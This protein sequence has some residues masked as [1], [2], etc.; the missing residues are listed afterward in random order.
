MMETIR[1]RRAGYPIR[2]LFHVREPRAAIHVMIIIS[3]L[4]SILLSVISTWFLS[5]LI[6]ILIS[7]LPAKLSVRESLETPQTTRLGLLRYFSR[8]KLYSIFY[9][10]VDF[11]FVCRIKMIKNLKKQERY[12]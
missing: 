12:S 6:I 3:L 10:V 2:H 1:I 8:Y 9:F 4:F 7:R 11:C 5:S